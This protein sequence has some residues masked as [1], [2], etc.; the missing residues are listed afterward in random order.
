MMVK[1][2]IKIKAAKTKYT[3]ETKRFDVQ[4]LQNKGIK[5]ISQAQMQNRYELLEEIQD[6]EVEQQ[7]QKIMEIW[8]ETAEEA[9]GF[10]NIQEGK[11]IRRGLDDS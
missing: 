7:W 11:Y 3:Q 1:L 10:K 8:S 4:K 5:E 6:K 2:R 9:L